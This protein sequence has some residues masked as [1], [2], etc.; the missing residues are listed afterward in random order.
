ML[1]P[2]CWWKQTRLR[3]Y[4]F[5]PTTLTVNSKTVRL[6]II[7]VKLTTSI[8]TFSYM[9]SPPFREN[10]SKVKAPGAGFPNAKAPK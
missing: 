3:G 10:W 5:Y 6:I 4:L 1:E 7:R 9:E 2:S 8:R